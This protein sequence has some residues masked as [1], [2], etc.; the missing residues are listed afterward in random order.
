MGL[1]TLRSRMVDAITARSARATDDERRSPISSFLVD[2]KL[3][4]E[5]GCASD[6]DK[7]QA[8]WQGAP[9]Q[10]VPNPTAEG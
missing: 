5:E 7:A 6:F 1:S 2:H 4:V 10:E 8:A 3:E 9:K